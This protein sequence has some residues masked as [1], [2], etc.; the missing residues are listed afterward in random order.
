MFHV[1]PRAYFT[2]YDTSGVV[3]VEGAARIAAVHLDYPDLTQSLIRKSQNV[4]LATDNWPFLYL[5]SRTIPFAVVIVLV[6][7]LYWC[8]ILFEARVKRSAVRKPGYIH[9][10]FLGAGF[11]LLETSGVTKLSL[12]FGSTW[13]VNAVV[14][15]SF[16][17][18]AFLANAFVMVKPFPQWKS[19]LGLFLSLALSVTFPYRVLDGLPSAQKVL[20]SAA[21]IGLPVFFSG[22]VFSRSFRDFMN[23]SAALGVNL[24]G[25]VVGGTLENSVMIGGTPILGALAVVLYVLSAVFL[26]KP[27]ERVVRADQPV[28]VDG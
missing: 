5:R 25:A 20:A 13:V 9:L 12:L 11:L 3:F 22:L 26:T 23:P 2:G 24:L 19:Y 17:L 15:A 6:P 4:V 7:F 28:A 18:M 10:F 8:F 14:I 21:L 27:L 1:P 16:I